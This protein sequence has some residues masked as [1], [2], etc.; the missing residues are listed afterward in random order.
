MGSFDGRGAQFVI[1]VLPVLGNVDSCF[2][3]NAKSCFVFS[4]GTIGSRR[5]AAIEMVTPLTFGRCSGFSGTMGL[6]STKRRPIDQ[7]G[8]CNPRATHAIGVRIE[9]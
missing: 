1:S 2:L 5:P 4:G 9:L 6:K 8:M 3:N 7:P